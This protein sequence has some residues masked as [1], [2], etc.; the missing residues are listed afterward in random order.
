LSRQR[1]VAERQKQK[2]KFLGVFKTRPW[3]HSI[4]ESV[5]AESSVTVARKGV[6]S[7]QAIFCF[8]KSGLSGSQ[9]FRKA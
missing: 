6:L 9:V 2:K 4:L 1:L 3:R 7:P 8:R 5:P